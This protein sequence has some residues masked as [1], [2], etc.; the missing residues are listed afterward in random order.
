MESNKKKFIKSV[1]YTL[2]SNLTSFFINAFI[3]LAVPK[4]IGSVEY[5]YFQYY[6][7]IATYAAYF[8]FGVCDGMVLK[9]SGQN[10]TSLDLKKLSMQYR[11]IVSES[12]FLFLIGQILLGFINRINS[13]KIYLFRLFLFIIICVNTR[14]FSSCIL[15]SVSRFKEYSR[16]I[17]IE[18]VIYIIFLIAALLLGTRDYHILVL[19]DVI[20]KLSAG[21]LGAYYCRDLIFTKGSPIKEAFTELADNF[22]IG[23]FILISNLS[24]LL[25]T[26]AIQLF[27]ENR[28]DIETFGKVSLSFNISKMLM[29]VINAVSFV[30]LPFLRNINEKKLPEM[31][32][33]IRMPLMSVLICLLL[34]YYPMKIVLELWLPKY[35]DSIF[36]ASLLFPMCLFESKTAMLINTYLKVLRKE[37]W[38][39]FANLITVILSF[40]FS[41][42]TVYVLNNL[43]ITVLLIPILFAIR[44]LLLERPLAKLLNISVMKEAIT[45]VIIA[46]VFIAFNYFL[47][48]WI[49]FTLYLSVV[50]IYLILHKEELLKV[51][52]I[53]KLHR[54]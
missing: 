14:V 40:I 45:E 3:L 4:I 21:L 53:K 1:S 37:K 41:L 50:I 26:G 38:L 54:K 28:W 30:L 31:Y 12:T 11:L 17:I 44:C 39:C 51:I 18:K 2:S 15:Q 35:N 27:V 42:F 16:V 32:S 49:A 25:I 33:K 10:Y 24:S 8:H 47:P 52:S 43:L 7:L 19:G 6:T 22:K 23:I 29:L 48:I 34:S 13:D 20:G 5:G 9:Y 36:Y 46:L